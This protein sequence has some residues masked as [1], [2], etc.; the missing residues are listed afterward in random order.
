MLSEFHNVRRL[1]RRA[2]KIPNVWLWEHIK[3]KGTNQLIPDGVHLS[4][5]GNTRLYFSMC[6]IIRELALH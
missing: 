6:T 3:M 5:V 1:D 4:K 2:L